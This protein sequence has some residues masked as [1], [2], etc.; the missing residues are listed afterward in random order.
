MIYFDQRYRGNNEFLRTLGISL[1]SDL[2][3]KADSVLAIV[4]CSWDDYSDLDIIFFPCNRKITAKISMSKGGKYLRLLSF[5]DYK[6]TLI[7]NRIY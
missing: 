3:I 2:E 4:Q 1:S 5:Q 7:N 6:K